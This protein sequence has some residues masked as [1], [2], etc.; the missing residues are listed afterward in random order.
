MIALFQIHIDN[1]QMQN[2]KNY[3]IVQ[4]LWEIWIIDEYIYAKSDSLHSI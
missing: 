2:Y 4:R 1:V 3:V